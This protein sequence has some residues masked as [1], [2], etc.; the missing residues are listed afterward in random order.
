MLFLSLIQESLAETQ[1]RVI[2]DVRLG[3]HNSFL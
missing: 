3:G 1:A 2:Q